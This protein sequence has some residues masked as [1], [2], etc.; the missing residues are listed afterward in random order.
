MVKIIDLYDP[1][2]IVDKISNYP[3][4]TND[5]GKDLDEDGEQ[6]TQIINDAFDVMLSFESTEDIYNEKL[7]IMDYVILNNLD[8][9]KLIV[10]LIN[11]NKKILLFNF[12]NK[13][14]Y[15]FQLITNIYNKNS[16]HILNSLICKKIIADVKINL[17]DLLQNNDIKFGLIQ[18]LHE[19]SMFN[20]PHLDKII[21]INE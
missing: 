17:S 16:Y 11:L 13:P 15:V 7:N 18:L 5:D 19:N 12:K 8:K 10:N 20:E 2:I 1:Q 4:I 21:Y 6:I 14:N 3:L 9:S